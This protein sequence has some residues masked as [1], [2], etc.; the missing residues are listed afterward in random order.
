MK[1]I[2]L[3]LC[4]ICAFGSAASGSELLWADFDAD[5]IGSVANLPGWTRAA[6]LNTQTAQVSSA[7]SYSDSH[8]LELPWHASGSSA[9][10]TNFS[11]GY[12]PTSAH[13]VIRFSAK[14]FTPNSNTFFQLGL[15]NAASGAFLSF[16]SEGGYG[17]FGTE[18]HDVVFV[19]LVTNR[20]A[21]V[22]FFYNRSNNYYRLDYDHTNRLAWGSNNAP[23]SVVHTQFNQ[24]VA[25][26]LTNGA[27]TTGL[28]LIDDVSV[29]A[30]PP[31]V[32]AWWRCTP[33]F[34]AQFVE[35][36]G[37]FKPT[38]RQGWSDS[39]RAGSSDPIWDGTADFRNAGATRQLRAGPGEAAMAMPAVTNWTVEAAVRM[40]PATWNTA[41]FD[42]GT[43]QG[44]DST[45]AWIQIG[46][47]DGG[48]VYLNLRD[49]QQANA[50]YASFVL[51]DYVP[52]GRWQHL[53]VV[54]SN[55]AVHLYVDYQP[56]TNLALDAVAD[57]SYA[58]PAA[59]QVAIG[60][61]LNNGNTTAADTLIDEVRFSTKALVPAEFLQPGQ[62]LIV[63]IDDSPTNATW[64]LTMKGILGKTYR[65]DTSPTIGP[66]ANWQAA[67]SRVADYVF[68]YVDVPTTVPRTNFVR[69]VRED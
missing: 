26:R 10:Q 15:R 66:S 55:A 17:T 41:F 13:P 33:E 11:A 28:L 21:D 47:N 20:F 25:T 24:F 51:R 61:T 27:A 32:W 42:W 40:D 4:L 12:H 1:T 53:A 60:A 59:A 38:L 52:N 5:P 68:N 39:A 44:F 19:P 45:S 49:S 30:F 37:S 2:R 57:G 54:K 65:L 22:T 9:V 14:L 56:V 8:C 48:Y 34:N 63:D 29:E 69:L 16:Q 46:Y 50:T 31:Y 64:K 36:L 23:S 18:T 43:N 7:G 6:W 67:T 58:F 62:P 3:C 35:Q